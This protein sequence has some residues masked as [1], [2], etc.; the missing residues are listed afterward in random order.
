[1]GIFG[2]RDSVFR[3]IDGTIDQHGRLT[4]LWRRRAFVE[5][6]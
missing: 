5:C 1:M 4:V 2:G 6:M 3:E